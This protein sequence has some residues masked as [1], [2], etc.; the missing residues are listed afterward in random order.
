MSYKGTQESWL[1]V[2]GGKKQEKTGW[3]W[4]RKLL[5]SMGLGNYENQEGKAEAEVSEERQMKG[6]PPLA[7]I[8]KGKVSEYTQLD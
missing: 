4:M 2:E 6:G 7:E 8:R 3:I 5:L 1:H